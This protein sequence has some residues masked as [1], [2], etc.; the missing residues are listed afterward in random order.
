MEWCSKRDA[1]A[2]KKSRYSNTATRFQKTVNEI[3]SVYAG[4]RRFFLTDVGAIARTP[5]RAH[6]KRPRSLRSRFAMRHD[7]REKS[8]RNKT[9]TPPLSSGSDFSPIYDCVQVRAIDGGKNLHPVER[10]GLKG[11]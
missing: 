5:M 4:F 10:G 2:A 6:T 3:H 7:V 8:A 11:R 9:P 1:M